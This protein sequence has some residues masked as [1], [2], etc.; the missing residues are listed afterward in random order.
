MSRHGEDPQKTPI[1][2]EAGFTPGQKT[3]AKNASGVGGRARNRGGEGGDCREDRRGARAHSGRLD[4]N[5]LQQGRPMQM[6]QAI[7]NQWHNRA[8]G[9]GD[10]KSRSAAKA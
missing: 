1:A 5:G 3:R 2:Q 10:S 7:P 8:H 4:R 6:A 9:K